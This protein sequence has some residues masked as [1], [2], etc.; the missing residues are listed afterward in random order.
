MKTKKPLQS[1]S[2]T[3]NFIHKKENIMKKQILILGICTILMCMTV[4]SQ[5][6]ENEYTHATLDIN[7]IKATLQSGNK[8]FCSIESGERAFIYPKNGTASTIFGHVLWIGGLDTN[9]QLRLAADN[10]RRV[11]KNFQPGILDGNA[12]ID[13]A[14]IAKWSRVW[15]LSANE[16]NTFVIASQNGSVDENSVPEAIKTWPAHGDTDKGE[17]QNIAPFFDNLK[18]ATSLSLIK[19]KC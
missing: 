1:K 13:N 18:S 8:Q 11:D 17:L 3:Q 5:T 14:T 16:I 19:A 9:N 2:N 7:N 6:E 12:A 15:K 10:I 4:Y